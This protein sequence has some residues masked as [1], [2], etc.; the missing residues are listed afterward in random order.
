MAETY[1]EVFDELVQLLDQAL[2]GADSRARHELS[3][4]LVDRAKADAARA[5]LPDEILAVLADTTVPDEQPGR[6]IRQRVGMPRLVAAR[7]PVE[8]RE[9]RDHGHFDLL[10]GTSTC[11]PSPRR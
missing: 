2:A 6:L 9:P 3:Q 5:R 10:A 1:V 11:A 8:E 4:R 7:R